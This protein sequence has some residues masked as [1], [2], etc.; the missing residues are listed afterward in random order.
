MALLIYG[1]TGF[2]G[3]L[4]SQHALHLSLPLILGGRNASK[5]S[6]L[7]TTLSATAP[8]APIPVRVFD[9]TANTQLIDQSLKGVAVLLNCAGPFARTAAPLI[10]ACI[11]NGVHYLDVAAE[12]VSYQ[13][14]EEKS[15]DARRKGVMLMPGAG[16]SVA[17]LGCLAGRAVAGFVAAEAEAAAK[18]DKKEEERGKQVARI[19]IA[20]RVAGPLSRGTLASAAEASIMQA[21]C[22]Q[23]VDGELVAQD[24]G[25]AALFDFHDGKGEVPCVPAS[26]P[27]LMTL[28]RSTGVLNVRTYVHAADGAFAEDGEQGEQEKEGPTAEERDKYPCRAAVMVVGADGRERREVLHTLNGYDFTAIASVRAAQRV[29]Q[30]VAEPGWQT[31]AGVFGDGFAF[32]VGR[33]ERIV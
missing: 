33:D 12:L 23:R 18:G 2:T 24:A 21:G 25:A 20:L 9:V 19:D 11:R 15:E 27:D 7:A 14:A 28:P 31:P 30:G 13:L 3:T 17:M 22:L 6:T 10:A 5:L 16:G 32:G 29:L 4:A 8:S 1:A 26:L